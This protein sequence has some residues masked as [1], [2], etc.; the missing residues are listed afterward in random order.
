MLAQAA[1]WKAKNSPLRRDPGNR[2]AELLQAL[3]DEPTRRFAFV[4]CNARI[5]RSHCGREEGT[6]GKGGGSPPHHVFWSLPQCVPAARRVFSGEKKG[7]LSRPCPTAALREQHGAACTTTALVFGV[8]ALPGAAEPG[9]GQGL[10]GIP[11]RQRPGHE[12]PLLP[13]SH[14]GHCHGGAGHRRALRDSFSFA[15][16]GFT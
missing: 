13:Q 16:S 2:R 10:L 12:A 1:R 3:R 14:P 6:G 8:H 11:G 5:M 7:G 15:H 4:E 9:V